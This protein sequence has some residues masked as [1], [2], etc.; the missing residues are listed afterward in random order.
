MSISKVQLLVCY[1]FGNVFQQQLYGASEEDNSLE[2]K[3]ISQIF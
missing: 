2:T 3:P 1:R